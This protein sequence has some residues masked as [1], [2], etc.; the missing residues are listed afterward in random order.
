MPLFV[1]VDAGGSRTVA[2]AQRDDESPQTFVGEAANAN[3]VG[4]QRAA[5][6]IAAA[7]LAASNGNRPDAIA[8][9]AAGAARREIADALAAL[10]LNRFPTTAITVSD[11]AQ[12]A[13]RGAVPAGDGLVLIAGTGSLAYAEIHGRTVRAGGGGFALGDDGS[14]YAIGAAALK[15]VLR[16]FDG[17]IPRD[18]SIEALAA[19]I[20]AAD[21][22]ALLSYVY[23]DGAPVRSVA[24]MAPIVLE[25]ADAGERN[26]VKI[27]Q[28]AALELFELVR[29]VCRLS[30]AT[31]EN[32]PIAFSGGLLQT[33]STL[34]YLI[35]TRIANELPYLQIVKGGGAPYFGALAA[36]RR[37]LA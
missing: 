33:N 24:A 25:L 2:A 7:A 12:I 26:A 16:C 4:L 34:T 31:A 5:D 29:S 19:R 22:G 15:L 18:G 36:A 9:G 8:V 17:R 1:G 6:A 20:G 21:R 14:G 30:G 10:L 11:D 3:V 32:L 35:E 37:L 13:L 23:N 28:A 27:V